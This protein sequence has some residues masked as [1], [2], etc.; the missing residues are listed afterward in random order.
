MLCKTLPHTISTAPRPG[1]SELWGFGDK[2]GGA[3]WQADSLGMY[4]VEVGSGQRPE[5]K[6]VVLD[7]TS[8]MVQ[9]SHARDKRAG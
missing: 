2:E 5:I 3:T 7:H 1:V 9:N 4:R 6:E 8:V